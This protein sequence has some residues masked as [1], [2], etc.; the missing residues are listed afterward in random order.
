M[1]TTRSSKRGTGANRLHSAQD[2]VAL[3]LLFFATSW[4]EED[5]GAGWPSQE[6]DDEGARG[7]LRTRKREGKDAGAG[8]AARQSV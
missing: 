4:L 6:Q 1:R 7:R 3:R 5:I 2:K 8:E